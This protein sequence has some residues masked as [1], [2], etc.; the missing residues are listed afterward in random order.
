MSRML[1]AL[2]RLESRRPPHLH[3]IPPTDRVELSVNVEVPDEPEAVDNP[4]LHETSA[5][6]IVEFPDVSDSYLPDVAALGDGEEILA[7]C[8]LE[9]S[10]EILYAACS[11]EIAA[12]AE[13]SGETEIAWEPAP[14]ELI[15]TQAPLD[16]ELSEIDPDEQPTE[17]D[18]T[19]ESQRV[20]YISATTAQE[21]LDADEAPESVD[22]DEQPT[23]LELPAAY[24]LPPV[25]DNTQF[26][27]ASSDWVVGS[28]VV[29]DEVVDLSALLLANVE[30][31]QRELAAFNQPLAPAVDDIAPIEPP[32]FELA[33]AAIEPHA[34]VLP[35]PERS[36]RPFEKQRRKGKGP[37]CHLAIQRS[38]LGG[39]R[40]LRDRILDQRAGSGPAMLLFTG[41]DSAQRESFSVWHLAVAFGERDAGEVL[42]VDA[43]DAAPLVPI[44][45][46]AT[47]LAD[48]LQGKLTWDDIR[49]PT[50]AARVSLIPQGHMPARIERSEATLW[51]E[52][53]QDYRVVLIRSGVATASPTL[54]LAPLC[55]ATYMLVTLQQTQRTAALKAQA[56]LESCGANL[57]GTIVVGSRTGK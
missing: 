33:P 17:L 50:N 31:L 29:G 10:P 43:D 56:A 48:A 22:E 2:K 1:A 38:Q 14:A 21:I 40:L 35:W 32:K 20:A 13:W 46:K 54:W 3:A 52:L 34:P 6:P 11:S 9:L 5:A 26:T 41:P 7:A 16:G 55:D 24:P 28:E 37:A 23:E 4:G 27:V 19:G 57:A 8:D 53:R 39:Y 18:L 30:T 12:A 45:P 49:R 42:I 47:G 15:T 51:D 44:A 25:P 36:H